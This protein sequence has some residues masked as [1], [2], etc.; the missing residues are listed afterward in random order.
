MTWHAKCKCNLKIKASEAE[1]KKKS[2]SAHR[3][4]LAGELEDDLADCSL[5]ASGAAWR[6]GGSLLSI[7]C[8]YDIIKILGQFY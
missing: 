1:A 3:G 2:V 5:A 6:S 4:T 7:E 8:Y